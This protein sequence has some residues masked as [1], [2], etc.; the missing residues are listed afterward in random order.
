MQGRT[1]KLPDRRRL[2]AIMAADIVGYSRLMEADE[3]ATLAAVRS[4]RTEVVDPLVSEHDGRIVKLMGDGAIVEFG[5]VVDA[6]ACAVA[7]QAGVR[8]HQESQP[9][10]RRITY[11]IGVN[12]G[13]VVV[14]GGD[15][16]G[17]GVNIAARLEQICP[18]GGVLVAAAA[19]D[20]LQ[21]KLDIVFDDEGE[22]QVKNITRPVRVYSARI[23]GVAHA[24]PHNPLPARR[25]IAIGAAA[26]LALLVA[27]GGVWFWLRPMTPANAKPS[28]IV[29]PFDNLSDDKEQGYL[30]D[31]IS[32]DLTTELAR[33]PGLIVISRKAAF[34]YKDKQVLPEQ[35]AHE[36]GVRYVLEG[37]V[38]RAGDDMRINAQLI[39]AASGAHLWAERFDGAWKDIFL[40]QDKVVRNAATALELR[41]TRSEG[42]TAPGGT[43]NPDAYQEFL[44]GFEHEIRYSPADFVEA[45]RHFRQATA[46]DPNYGHA[47]AELAWVYE[48]TF[49]DE[50][51]ERALGI[52]FLEAM[53]LATSALETAMRNPSASAYQL[54]A[55]RHMNHWQFDLAI[56]E[57]QHA[58]ALN[59]SDSW[60]YQQMSEAQTLSAHPQEGLI[61]VEAALRVDPRESQDIFRLRGLAYFTLERYSDAAASLEKSLRP[62]DNGY[63]SLLPLMASYGKLGTT[64]RFAKLRKDLDSYA[65]AVGDKQVTALLAAQ[66]ITFDKPADILRLQDGLVKAGIPELPFEFDPNSNDRLSGDEMKK[67]LFG[68]TVAGHVLDRATNAGT[69]QAEDFRTGVA[70]S[71][72]VAADGSGVDYTWGD[73]ADSGGHSHFAGNIGCFYHK[74]TGSCGAAFRNPAGAREQQSEYFWVAPWA[75]IAFSPVR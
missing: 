24:L 71:L 28:M 56:S 38:R 65:N 49:G 46:L 41:L 64:D 34:T 40:L 22:R 11:R 53:R 4:I 31:G 35:I 6:V 72:T 32:E 5:S 36:M 10:D 54:I 70:F 8:A 1:D 69:L 61:F 75:V 33:I 16:M 67:L 37:S 25:R 19:H 23:E 12:L 45:V 52:G 17:D 21:G 51:F 39:E 18:P 9:S 20:Q 58:I 2:A 13:D 44:Q 14:E 48:Q 42:D 7:I 30:A 50:R 62:N 59:P 29:L 26:V 66:T 68:H 74:E 43:S 15:L 55:R 60:S 27:I 47:W 63:N 73:V 57:L 3:R